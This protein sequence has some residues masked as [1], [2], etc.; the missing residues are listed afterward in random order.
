MIWLG[1]GRTLIRSRDVDSLPVLHFQ[2]QLGSLRYPGPRR[3][4]PCNSFDVAFLYD[5]VGRLSN[6]TVGR[7][8]L[9]THGLNLSCY[10]EIM[11]TGARFAHPNASID[12]AKHPSLQLL[13]AWASR[14]RNILVEHRI[15]FRQDV[16]PIRSFSVGRVSWR[17]STVCAM[18]G[19]VVDSSQS[20]KPV[21][22]RVEGA[23]HKLPQDH[24]QIVAASAHCHNCPNRLH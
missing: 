1:Q 24:E 22:T 21:R 5:R 14:R 3:Q 20:S 4:M 6:S 13:H 17:G 12:D 2:V 8:H 16:L 23:R 7:L 19:A 10:E 9:I 11:T 18:V 15:I